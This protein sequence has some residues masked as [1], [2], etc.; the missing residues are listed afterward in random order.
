MQESQQTPALTAELTGRPVISAT[1]LF[2]PPESITNEELVASFNAFVDRH[3]AANPDA[4]P[5]AGQVGRHAPRY[6]NRDRVRAWRSRPMAVCGVGTS[7]GCNAASSSKTAA[8][9]VRSCASRRSAFRC[10]SAK[11]ISLELIA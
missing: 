3:N 7:F 6:A 8:Q 1:G 2:T 11:A 10:D 9:R 5:L 4:E